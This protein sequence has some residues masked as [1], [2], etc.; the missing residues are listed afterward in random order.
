MQRLKDIVLYYFRER[1]LRH[2]EEASGALTLA[3][4]GALTLI[5]LFTYASH[6]VT[7]HIMERQK[8]NTEV[9]Y[10]L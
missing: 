4:V 1:F 9:S 7:A 8:E 2:D 3:Y 10:N 5:A 6:M